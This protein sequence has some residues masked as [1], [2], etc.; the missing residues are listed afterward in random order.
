MGERK[1]RRA[2][3]RG[4]RDLLL[5]SLPII[6]LLWYGAV[7]DLFE[8]THRWLRRSTGGVE[9][10]LLFGLLLMAA[11]ASVFAL[12]RWRAQLRES[13]ARDSAESRYRALIEQMPAVLYT[14]D[15]REPA[16]K[17][18]TPYVSPQVE[19][20]LGFTVE[21]WRADPELW[22][23]QLHPEDR[24]R[25]LAA[26]AR[27]DRTGEP[28]AVEYRHVR[29]DGQVVWIRDEAVVA[30][31][32]R[33]GRPTLAQGIMYDITQRREAEEAARE[34][35]AR[36]RALVEQVPAVTY[37][38]D[39]TVEP[40]SGT[41]PYVSPQIEHLLGYSAEEW[42]ED[43][44]LGHQRIHDDDRGR[45]LEERALAV[46][47]RA[48]FASEYRIHA[49]DGR[50]LWLRD[51]AVPVSGDRTTRRL[52][53][54][55]M[56]DI[57]QR[58]QAEEQLRRAEETY[59]T[60]V[61]QLPV[62]VYQDAVDEK[63]TALYISPQYERVFGFA[64]EARMNDP[65]FW[66]DH[67][68]PDDRERVL[69]ESA[70]TNQTGDPFVMDY[71]FLARDGRVVWV[72][73]EAILF[74][75][76]EDTPLYWQ[77][78]LLDITERKLVE[79][80][81]SRRDAVLE[82][83]GFAAERFL[84]AD[85][86]EE[87][88][89][90]VLARLGLAGDV[91]RVYVFENDEL[92]DGGAAMTIHREWL[93]PGVSSIDEPSN[94]GLPYRNG[95]ARWEAA[96]S[97][98]RP[99]V[100][101]VRDFP[102][103][104]R[105][106]MQAE[107]V[108]SAAI[109]PVFVGEAWW[110]F[111]GLDDC[112]AE[113]E[114]PVA[115]IE[116]LKAAADTLGAAIGRARAARLQAETEQ[117]YRTL[118]EQMPAVTYVHEPKPSGAVSYVS[119]QIYPLLGYAPEER[120]FTHE[121]W[122][123][124]IHPED[125]ERVLAEDERTD[126]TGEPFDLEYRQVRKDGGIIWVRDTAVLV[127]SDDGR[128][129]YWQGVRFDITARKE[130]EEQ[131]GVAQER[132]RK[133]VETI[134]AVLYIDRVD[135]AP[136]NLYVSPQI[137]PLFGYTVDEWSSDAD[138]WTR[139]LH[140]D[141]RERSL[142]AVRTHNVTGTPLDLEYRFRAGDGTWRWVRDQATVVRDEHGAPALSQGLMSDITALKEA[143]EQLRETEAKY[144]AIVE[145]VPAAIYVDRPDGSMTSIYVSPQVVD[146]LGVTPEAFLADPD[147]WL[148][149]VDDDVRDELRRSYLQAISEGRS[150]V[151]EYLVHTPDGRDVW[152]RDET[153]FVLDEQ[154]EPLFLQGVLYDVTERKLAE[155][156]LRESERR[157]RDA[158]ER[159]RALDEM[160]N[161]FLAAVSHELRSPLTSILGLSLT[162][163][164][165]RLPEEDQ[166]DLLG[167]LA[168]NAR[169][170]DRLL[171]DLLDIDRLNRGI[172]TP[173]YRATDIGALV[174]RT[175]ESL[176]LLGERPILVEAEPVTIEVDP[177]KVERIVE[178]LLANAARHTG[179][180]TDIWVRVWAE[181]DGAV[182]AVED[183]GPGVP[184]DLQDAIFEPFRQGPTTSP[185]SPGTGIGLSL[186]AMFAELHGG[187]AWV[188]DREGG[189]ASFRVFLPVMPAAEHP[190]ASPPVSV[191]ETG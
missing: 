149:L 115:E 46:R 106:G 16:G 176:D 61:E 8:S 148:Q 156:T 78:V 14:W 66:I 25:V 91:S 154:G 111:L 95:F 170:L 9:D 5:I 29:K 31:R 169:K 135:D 139:N 28:L 43:P 186:V 44:Q 64:P 56:Y 83:V 60:L 73:D 133:L 33:W 171:K 38:W 49:R 51:E 67:L 153:T 178:N 104:E 4:L 58:K 42:R 118:V 112:V 105:R 41:P 161:T 97:A 80:T 103:P 40:G 23:R 85:E 93:A 45:V 147:L 113:R 162:L 68:H 181:P 168:T 164:Q 167:R 69:E 22:I 2:G 191:S 109:V 158:A 119:P 122:I 98:G 63:S 145:H 187:R 48:A 82:A 84:R 163:E 65:D 150:W 94:R 120:E 37:T 88:L 13:A 18:S 172:V 179:P 157:E 19:E 55:V 131:V 107:L 1:Q 159:L 30:E 182:I 57:T 75:D 117:R 110:G 180:D 62:V 185:H 177:A 137:E 10:E 160:K 102:E 21:E 144:R 124:S 86:P 12:L 141:D 101:V 125:R 136:A 189:G 20:I 165:T 72:R 34:A 121:T 132:Y 7:T 70:R 166:A 175:V 50:L 27:A 146:I 123:A 100:G 114:W 90:E 126:A 99:I 108:L 130:A 128:P 151:G 59:R 52:Y 11:G 152:V 127:R 17:A 142:E 96:L 190:T 54:G 138:L 24:E 143:Q 155:Q 35:E 15:P 183:D 53:Q 129:L 74:R 79:E 47:T 76:R 81:L 36:Y 116:A 140:P 92:E 89:D 6:G 174:R 188:Q 26:S 39:P 3:T 32:D 134:S 184:T 173:N 71:R 87:V 77:G